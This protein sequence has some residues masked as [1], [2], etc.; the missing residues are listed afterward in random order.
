MQKLDYIQ[1]LGV[2]TI[3]LP[4]YPS[5]LRDDGYDI[6]DYYTVNPAYG[7]R[8]DFK[9]FLDQAISIRGSSSQGPRQGDRHDVTFTSGIK[10][11]TTIRRRALFSR[12][13]SIPTGPGM[14]WRS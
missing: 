10:S 6:A 7:T 9:A 1:R 5:P 13:S 8:E 11:S 4:F 12:I 14:P 2:T 3:W